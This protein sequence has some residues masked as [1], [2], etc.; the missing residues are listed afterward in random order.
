V[1][2]A[3]C[4]TLLTVLLASCGPTAPA[5]AAPTPRQAEV[6]APAAPGRWVDPTPGRLTAHDVARH[7]QLHGH[8]QGQPGHTWAHYRAQARQLNAW[9]VAVARAQAA[10]RMAACANEPRC[11]VQLASYLTRAPY[12]LVARVVGCESGWNPGASNP[13]SS[14]GGLFQFLAGTWASLAPQWGM[15][16]RSRYEVWP[17]A[18]VGAGTIAQGGIGHWNASRH[19][20]G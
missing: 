7:H 18:L 13:A 15:G 16:H 2:R 19:C 6:A 12:G 8:H 4:L 9:L 1:R 14:A 5:A 3:L 11:A 17:A 10:R 20:W